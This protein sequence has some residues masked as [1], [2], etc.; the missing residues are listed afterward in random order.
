MTCIDTLL[1]N[2]VGR[3]GLVR[4][5]LN[6]W[7]VLGLAGDAGWRTASAAALPCPKPLQLRAAS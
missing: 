3:W 6:N 5:G 1:F 7:A 2:R 4:F